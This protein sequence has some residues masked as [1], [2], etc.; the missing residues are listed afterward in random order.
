MAGTDPIDVAFEFVEAINRRDLE[1][2]VALMTHDHRFVDLSGEAH[3]GRETMRKAWASYF[4]SFPKY[5]IHVAELFRNDDRVI[6]VGRT[7]GSHLNL[8]RLVEFNETMIW[9]AETAGGL[10]TGWLLYEDSPQNRA[11]LGA[12]ASTRIA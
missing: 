10:V 2:L 9:L 12:D 11:Q 5:M 3:L 4:D 1:R 7:T 6:M 8:P